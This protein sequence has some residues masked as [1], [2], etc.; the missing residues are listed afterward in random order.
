MMPARQ[1]SSPG[2]SKAS[3][4]VLLLVLVALVLL[5]I[6]DFALTRYGMW[7][8]FATESNRVMNFFFQRGDV[9]AGL[10]KFSIVTGGAAGLWLLRRHRAA[11]LGG[12]LLTAVFSA[13]VT[14]QILWLVSL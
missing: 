6:A 5:N 13:V 10:F 12:I 3:H 11:A 1:D 2:T 14:Y 9:V 7:L 4:R 8:G